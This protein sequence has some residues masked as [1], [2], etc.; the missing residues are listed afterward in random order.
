MFAHRL[1]ISWWAPK[2]CGSSIFFSS[3]TALFPVQD[4]L[5]A[6]HLPCFILL[7]CL[8]IKPASLV[9]HNRVLVWFI[10]SKIFCLSNNP[11]IQLVVSLSVSLDMQWAFSWFWSEDSSVC[12]IWYMRENVYKHKV[13]NEYVAY[14]GVVGV[15]VAQ[16][17]YYFS[18]V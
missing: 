10:N 1:I 4:V 6:N 12:H 11:G 14:I 3:S 7:F 17:W 18:A 16:C 15:S 5:I 2:H 13:L 9:K 8:E